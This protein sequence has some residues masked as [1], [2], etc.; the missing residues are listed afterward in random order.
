[1][2]NQ[3]YADSRDV[4][5]WTVL[6]RLATEH[7]L[8]TILQIAMLTAGDESPQGRQRNDPPVADPIVAGF[9]VDERKA[10]SR[11]GSLRQIDRIARL[12]DRYKP[13]IT[14]DVIPDAFSSGRR[15]DYFDAACEQISRGDRPIVAFVDP[16]TGISIGRPSDRHIADW[17]LNRVWTELKSGSLLVAFQYQQRRRDWVN[18]SRQRFTRALQ[19]PVG[20]VGAFTYPSVCFIFARK[21]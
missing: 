2:K 5:K 21:M 20:E 1:M 7:G 17:E 3:Y 10:I 11:D 19:T 18:D 4:A 12:G 13:P 14:I 15:G 9:F 16:D 8:T 6:M